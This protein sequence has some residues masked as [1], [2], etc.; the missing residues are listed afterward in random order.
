VVPRM[1]LGRVLLGLAVLPL[2][3][4]L[5]A[6]CPKPKPPPPPPEE[7][8]PPRPDLAIESVSPRETTEGTPVTVYLQGTGFA[9]GSEVQLGEAVARGVD[10][11]DDRELSFRV[12]ES[13]A[14][15][16]HDIK[17]TTPSGEHAVRRQAFTVL[18]APSAT[19]DCSLETVRF[20]YNEAS[21]TGSAQTTLANNAAC[22]ESQEALSVQ[23][24]GHADDRGSTI[25]NLSL[26]QRRAESVRQYLLNIGITTNRLVTLSYGEERPAVRGQDEEAWSMNRRVEFVTR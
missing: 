12:S 2:L 13:V 23:L 25:Y 11:I 6:G 5:F 1:P 21:L 14:V 8:A 9:P 18:P 16:K 15:G 20:D 4:V 7:S 17:V 19:N 22:L 10:V 24:V 3:G 26:G